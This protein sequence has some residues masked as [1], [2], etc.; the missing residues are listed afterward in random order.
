MVWLLYGLF[1]T[2]GVRIVEMINVQRFFVHPLFG[3][4]F[5]ARCVHPI[6]GKVYFHGSC[7]SIQVGA[8]LCVEA[9]TQLV[10]DPAHRCA[11]PWGGW[12][13]HKPGGH[14]CNHWVIPAIHVFLR[15][16]FWLWGILPKT[17]KSRFFWVFQVLKKLWIGM[18]ISLFGHTLRSILI[19]WVLAALGH[20]FLLEQPV[21]SNFRHFPQWRFFC[22]YICRVTF[23]K[24]SLNTLYLEPWI[25]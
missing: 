25:W 1:H 16:T 7:Q 3:L 17:E 22:K 24:L 19:C 8:A 18:V 5:V 12:H 11:V 2:R 4:Y 14:G 23:L 13:P 6:R 20:V 21:G 9:P 10:G 15:E